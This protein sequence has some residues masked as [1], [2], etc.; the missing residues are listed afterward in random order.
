[1]N[2]AVVQL[3]NALQKGEIIPEPANIDRLQPYIPYN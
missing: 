1:M 3:M 2:Q